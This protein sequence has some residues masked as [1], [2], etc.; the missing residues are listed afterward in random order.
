[1]GNIDSVIKHAHEHHD[2]FLAG[3]KELLRI[4]SISTDPAYTEQV[5]QAA[6]WLIDEMKRIGLQNCQVIPTAKHPVVYGDWLKAGPEQPTVLI[7]AHYDVQPVDPLEDWVTGPFE[8]TVRDDKLFA[9][10]SIDDKVGVFTH[11]KAIESVL[12]TV[13]QLPIN[14][15]LIFEGEE[16]IGSPSAEAFIQDH[17]EL[18]AADVLVLSDGGSPKDQPLMTTSIRGMAALEVEVTGPE[19]DLHSGAYGGVVHNPV[20]LVGKIIGALHD[21]SGRIQVPGLYDDVLPLTAQERQAALEQ[22]QKYSEG[23]APSF[24]GVQQLWGEPKEALVERFSAQPSCDVNGV[25]GGYSGPGTK[26]IIPS[27]AGFKLTLRLVANQDPKDIAAKVVKF[28]EG[29]AVPTLDLKVEVKATGWF[30]QS[31]LDSAAIRAAA[32]AIETTWGQP[33][34]MVRNG[35]SV[36]IIGLMQRVLNLQYVPLGFG[37]GK[38]VHAPNEYLHLSHFGRGIDTAIHFY[39]NLAEQ[40][41]KEGSGL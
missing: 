26:T 32:Q 10:G 20:H 31:A 13:G 6:D 3:F 14:V 18:L 30:A 23:Y 15:K 8:P 27:Q 36:P 22:Q 2:E 37:D 33:P 25:Y 7:Y 9:R 41:K 1:M 34:A 28:I 4:P 35:G 19:R 16:E 21:D 17:Q 11:L 29:F 24:V 40:W 38:N 12:Q 5:G 39:F